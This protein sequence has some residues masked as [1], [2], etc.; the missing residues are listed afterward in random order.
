MGEETVVALSGRIQAALRGTDVLFRLNR[1][2]FVVILAETN[3]ENAE[4]V[5]ERIVLEVR[6]GSR[7]HTNQLEV[8]LGRV[9]MGT[10][11]A[12]LDGT[13]LD[14]LILAARRRAQ[15]RGDVTKSQPSIH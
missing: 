1:E 12:P 10:A 4:H 13:N 8:H 15:S 3:G 2:E 7:S 9:S 11:T 6:Q 5:A 14:E